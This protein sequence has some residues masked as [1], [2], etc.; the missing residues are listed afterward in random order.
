MGYL[1]RL[2]RRVGLIPALMMALGGGLALS[3][4]YA[5][6]PEPT[7][8]PL[9]A[10][11]DARSNRSFSSSTLA[12]TPDGRNLVVA[13]L[14][15][16]SVSVVE[17]IVPNQPRLVVEIPV[18]VDPRAVAVTPDGARALVTTR[19]DGALVVIDL[20]AQ[21]VVQSISLGGALPYGVLAGRND[22][23]L[24]SLQGSSEIVEVDL[25]GGQVLRRMRVD[26]FPSGLALWGDFLYITHFW[27]GRVSLLYL[28]QGRVID[29]RRTGPDIS[30]SQ[31]I[32]LDI[33]RGIAYLPQ[34]RS[35]FQNRD[36]TFDTTVF[37]VVN[38]L[39]LRGLMPLPRARITLDTA[40]RPVNMPF[41][42]ALDRFRNWL[43]V[44]NAGSNDISVIDLNT[45]LA[46]ATIATGANPRGLLLN[47]DNTYLFVHNALDD[48]ITVVE[49]N[50]LIAVDVLPIST[51]NVPVDILIGAQLFHSADD[52][53]LS[54]QNWVSCANC[55]FDGQSDGRVWAG[56][57]GGPRN[58]PTLYNLVETAPYNALNTWD[59]LADIEL[60]IRALQAG[61]GLIEDFPLFPPLGDPH[62]GLSL[63]LDT[64]VTS[65]IAMRGPANPSILDA[66]QV[67]R[68]G[69]L[70]FELGCTECHLEPLGANVAL[71]D[72][73]TGGAIA[74][75]QMRYLWMSAP[76]F[77]DGSA[78]TLTDV[79]L[80]PG[81]H[82]LVGTVTL[83]EIDALVDYLLSR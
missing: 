40:D 17:V 56:F 22:R 2:L 6:P 39:D 51:L 37:P 29:T 41:A 75:P 24:V 14:L 26:P 53:R 49:T 23:A 48:S 33:T 45:G 44:A 38:L 1:T 77:H 5:Q 76:F 57:P 8:L 69:E 70:Y 27:D 43:Y 11:P 32:E 54:A 15:N 63:D 83:E 73:G 34:T 9:F 21:A 79:F 16:G 18:G 31:A 78:P 68:G 64:L 80:L 36:L 58:T 20:A 28:P 42:L 10:L 30:I 61:T 67:A 82:Q 47:R 74:V 65:L 66:E 72:V 12:L 19:G 59:E 50:R 62:A 35:N 25:N 13:N 4:A 60:K 55:H 3:P 52:P 71:F 81:A 46:R 7:P